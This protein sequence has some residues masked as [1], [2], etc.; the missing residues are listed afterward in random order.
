[1]GAHQAHRQFD[2]VGA[3][4]HD[5]IEDQAELAELVFL[6]SPYAWWLSPP[7]AVENLAREDVAGLDNVRL[8]GEGTPAGLTGSRSENV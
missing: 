6:P 4:Q 8:A 2:V 1:L 3:P 5:R 7:V